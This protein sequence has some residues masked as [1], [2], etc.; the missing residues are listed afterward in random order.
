MSG[1][2][3]RLIL[4]A[5]ISPPHNQMTPLQKICGS[6]LKAGILIMLVP[7][8]LVGIVLSTMGLGLSFP[9]CGQTEECGGKRER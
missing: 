5:L 8:A 1:S 9:V 3:T 6:I 7:V 4:A 2:G